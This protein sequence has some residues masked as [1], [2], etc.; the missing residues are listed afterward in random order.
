MSFRQRCAAIEGEEFGQRTGVFT[1]GIVSINAGF[2]VALFFTGRKHAGENLAELLAQESTVTVVRSWNVVLLCGRRPVE[3]NRV[4]PRFQAVGCEHPLVQ[5]SG[6]RPKEVR[7]QD[8]SLPIDDQHTV[9]G[10]ERI[11]CDVFVG[12]DELLPGP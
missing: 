2:K 1:S 8:R 12:R 6:R 3:K 7:S 9:W 11:R 5:R 4:D 10:E